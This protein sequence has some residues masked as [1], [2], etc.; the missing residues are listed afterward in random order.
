MKRHT[1]ACLLLTAA[2][3]VSNATAQARGH[4]P[5]GPSGLSERVS[6]TT[7]ASGVTLTHIVRGQSSPQDG[8]EVEVPFDT[9]RS[10][11]QASDTAL[12]AAGFSPRVIGIQP[13]KDTPPGFF[14]A[15]IRLGVFPTQAQ[16]NSMV[17]ELARKG[18][19]SISTNYTGFDGFQTTTGPWVVNIVDVDP[20]AFHGT[21]VPVRSAVS[22]GRET[23][24]SI[25]RRTD[26]L[27]AVNGGY[28]VIGS[29]DGTPGAP[30]GLSAIEGDLY[31]EATEG[32]SSLGFLSDGESLIDKYRTET[33]ILSETGS[34][35]QVFGLN[36]RPGIQRDCGGPTEELPSNHPR[37][38]FDCTLRDDL[39]LFTPAFGPT[40]DSGPASVEAVLDADD[41]VISVTKGGDIAIPPH[42]SVL[43]ALGAKATWLS[44]H[45]KPGLSL[46]VPRGVFTSFGQYLPPSLKF[47]IVNAGPHLVQKGR[48][49]IDATAEGFAYAQ[50]G[51]GDEYYG[52]GL[53][54]NPRTLAGRTKSGHLLLVTVDGR[55]PGYSV[56]VSF[57]ESARLMQSLGCEQA[58]NLD[59]GGSTTIAVDGKLFNHPSDTAGERAVGEAIVVKP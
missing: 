46:F 47:N 42:G 25:A 29:T 16:A 3:P 28:F 34:L 59:G 51:G 21:V 27:V 56:G 39:V 30:V 26:A 4:L 1:A 9:D 17:K 37:Q 52:F 49:D 18:F 43:A 10:S 58:T 53:S 8:Y 36:R 45:A 41:R 14:G 15:I 48:L 22:E 23:T 35:E 5:L 12:I 2:I 13:P 44:A 24:S 38:D 11:V 50:P 19:T 7:L 40:T 32:R 20:A 57:D 55:Q 33:Y 6:S 54:R 31:H